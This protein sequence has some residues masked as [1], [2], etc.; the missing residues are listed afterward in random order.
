MPWHWAQSKAQSSLKTQNE[1]VEMTINIDVC[2]ATI[3]NIAVRMHHTV[4]ERIRTERG[5][6]PPKVR[7]RYVQVFAD[8]ACANQNPQLWIGIERAPRLTLLTMFLTRI[9]FVQLGLQG[10]SQRK[11]YTRQP[12][13]ISN[14]SIQTFYNLKSYNY[15]SGDPL[16]SFSINKMQSATDSPADI[17][18]ASL[19][20]RPKCRRKID[21]V[22]RTAHR[23]CESAFFCVNDNT[24]KMASSCRIS[25]RPPSATS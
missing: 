22:L 5:S 15:M 21:T 10:L 25:A 9:G 13:Q 8:E 17:A 1:M 18:A 12:L 3:Q 6:S 19:A 20:C 2:D 23:T 24:F 14:W 7:T 4:K 16:S 11:H